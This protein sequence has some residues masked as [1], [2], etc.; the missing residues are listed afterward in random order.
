MILL[1][2][3]NFL[4]S[5]NT[6]MRSEIGNPAYRFF[7][8]VRDQFPDTFVIFPWRPQVGKVA[9]LIC[10]V[11]TAEGEPFSGDPRFVLKKVMS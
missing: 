4:G 6:N 11:Y 7:N 3:F 5:V 1:V 9:R 10:D 8:F 2:E